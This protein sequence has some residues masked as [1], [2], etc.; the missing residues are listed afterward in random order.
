MNTSST[1]SLETGDLILASDTT[2]WFSRIVEWY[3]GSQWSHIGVVLRD[4]VY[5]DPSLHGLYL[6]ESGYETYSDAEDHVRKLG[7]QITNLEQFINQYQGKLVYR[8]LC[9]ALPKEDIDNKLSEIHQIIH[10]RPYDLDLAD[11]FSVKLEVEKEKPPPNS[12]LAG[13]L[14]PNHRKTDRF[15]CSAL[16][17]FIYTMLGFLPHDLEWTECEPK[18]F[19]T[20]NPKLKD[21]LTNCSLGPEIV[22]KEHL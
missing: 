12:A 22:I 13:W 9:T 1:S 7:V 10:G 5:I 6:L 19:S 3:T 4:P 21:Y 2:F 20:E 14:Q 11:L 8:K 17:G 16:V 18:F 15:Y